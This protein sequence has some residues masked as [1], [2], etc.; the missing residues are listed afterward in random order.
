MILEIFTLT[1]F[2]DQLLSN[3][4]EKMNFKNPNMKCKISWYYGQWQQSYSDMQTKLG[5]CIQFVQ[6]VTEY[7]D[8]LGDIYINLL[9]RSVTF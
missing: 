5:K 3:F 8:D 6:S 9:C 2:V 4:N 1:Y 7:N